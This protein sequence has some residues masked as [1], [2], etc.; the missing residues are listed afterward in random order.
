MKKMKKMK[1][2]KM[3]KLLALVS[4]WETGPWEKCDTLLTRV[5][6]RCPWVDRSEAPYPPKRLRGPTPS[7]RLD[8]RRDACLG[9]VRDLRA[10]R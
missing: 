9:L 4:S 10:S 7:A 2:W 8:P 3:K 6:T 5:V 1:K